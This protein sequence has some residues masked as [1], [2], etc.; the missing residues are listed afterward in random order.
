MAQL[1]QMRQRIKAI[2]T[3]K[4]ITHAM[5]LISMST[6]SRIRGKMPLLKEYNT[7][8]SLL[9]FKIRAQIPQWTNPVM[10]PPQEPSTNPLIILVGSQKGLCGTFNINLLKEFEK[11]I[12]PDQLKKTNIIAVGKKAVDYI[13]QKETKSIIKVFNDLNIRNFSSISQEI[14]E[15]ILYNQTPYSSVRV[16]SNELRTF[17]I[18]KP[19]FVDLIPLSK[20]LPKNNNQDT[21]V[22]TKSIDYVWYQ[23]PIEFLN[24][25]AP[26]YIAAS[27]NATLLESLLAEQAARFISMDTANR[28]A[29]TLLEET[30]LQYNKLRQAKITKELTELAT[31]Y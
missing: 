18:Q 10:F 12:D 29:K 24:H 31:N 1:I 11:T 4:K 22:A 6:H 2:E 16:F 9:F 28:N 26:Q 14:I 23:E 17:F 13:T 5:R 15:E 19:R 20:K 3:I 27:I 8:V 7:Q 25:I 21:Q 30:K